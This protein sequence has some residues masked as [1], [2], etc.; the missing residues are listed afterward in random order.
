MKQFGRKAESEGGPKGRKTRIV[1]LVADAA[2]ALEALHRMGDRVILRADGSEPNTR[3]WRT[4]MEGAFRRA[5]IDAKGRKRTPHSSRHSI[6]SVLLSRGV[7]N[8]YIKDILGHFDERTTE[9]YLH[10]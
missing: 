2:T 6:A 9:G 7:P 8:E 10:M 5:N 1:P 4:A 3:D